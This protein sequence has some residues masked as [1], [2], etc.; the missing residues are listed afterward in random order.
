MLGKKKYEPKLFSY[1]TIEDLVPKENF[2]RKVNELL[3]LRFLYDECKKYYGQTG[4][5][6]IDPVVFFKFTLYGYFENIIEDRELIRQVKDS[7]SA[8]LFLGYDLDEAIPW[9]STISRTRG[10]I[11]EEVFEKLFNRILEMCAEAG[12]IEGKHQS[13]D[14]TLVKANASMGAMEKK[15]PLLSVIEYIK[16]TKVNNIELEVNTDK[17]LEAEK[18]AE[19]KDIG[20]KQIE[21]TTE[22]AG[23]KKDI[24]KNYVSKTD[25]DSKVASKPNTKTDL[26]YSTHYVVDSKERIITDVLAVHADRVDSSVLLESLERANDRLEPLGM[27]IQEVG[28]DKG[29]SKGEVFRN[30]EEKNIEAYIPFQKYVNTTGKLDKEEFRY[31]TENDVY[32]CPEGKTAKYLSYDEKGQS[33]KYMFKKK[34][35]NNCPLR[36]KC[37]GGKSARQIRRSIYEEEYQRTEQRLKTAKGKR[38]MRLRKINTE[39]LFSEAKMNH[40]LRKF[41]TR[42]I[43]KAQKNLF[44][45]A[46]VQNL[47]RLIKEAFKRKGVNKRNNKTS[48]SDIKSFVNLDEIISFSY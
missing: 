24:N 16:K 4:K 34:D 26:Y 8:R 46:S 36:Q 20:L 45:I 33:K 14:S 12:L 17:S 3:D 40:G 13:V 23:K 1:V 28:A 32:I 47:K 38:A 43:K 48:V 5:P 42:G 7:L 39:P 2:Y 41:M 22:K 9:H 21:C 44:M 30:L 27:K 15:K 19:A 29:F 18:T 6:S 35:C 25:S 11:E 31:D 10:I 37:C